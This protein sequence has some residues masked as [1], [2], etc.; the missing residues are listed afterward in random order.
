M[1]FQ[2]KMIIVIKFILDNQNNILKTEYVPT[3]TLKII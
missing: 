1:Q 3:N 2:V